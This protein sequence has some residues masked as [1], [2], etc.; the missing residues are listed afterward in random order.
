[1]SKFNRHARELDTIAKETFTNYREAET[2][3]KAAQ[4]RADELR[5]HASESAE[6]AAK[7]AR[8]QATLIEA[9]ENMRAASDEFEAGRKSIKAIRDRLV[10]EISEEYAAKPE[11]IDLATIELMKAGVMSSSEYRRI[12]DAA[13]A[14][15][16]STMARI[17]AKYAAGEAEKAVRQNGEFDEEASGF[18]QIVFDGRHENGSEYLEAF[19]SFVNVYNRT[20]HNT[21]LIG[22]WDELTSAAI[23][24]F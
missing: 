20:E 16:N 24:N 11:Q 19:D 7:Y 4:S 22:Y 12:F 10:A 15:G 13:R 6:N 5:K 2:Q 8:A 1:M 18:R 17:I 3:L 14:D 23:E 9:K 21:A